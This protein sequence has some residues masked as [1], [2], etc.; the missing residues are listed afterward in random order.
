MK[1]KFL[2]TTLVIG[3]VAA[4]AWLFPFTTIG[5]NTTAA[6]P[7]TLA[8]IGELETQQKEIA[9]NQAEIEQSMAKVTESIR[10]ARIYV[11]RSGKAGGK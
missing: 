9:A 3:L 6:D 10:V 2:S 4:T 7:A 8:L 11:S 1:T 5:Q